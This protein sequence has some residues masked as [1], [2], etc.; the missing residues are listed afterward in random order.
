M[1]N[2][3]LTI[4]FCPSCK[5]KLVNPEDSDKTN[6]CPKCRTW[7]WEIAENFYYDSKGKLI[8]RE[9]GITDNDGIFIESNTQ[10]EAERILNKAFKLF[11]EKR[12]KS[13]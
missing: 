12:K 11:K 1:K 9:F 10:K 5:W 4:L 3:D 2:K 6:Y 13:P 8:G 7:T